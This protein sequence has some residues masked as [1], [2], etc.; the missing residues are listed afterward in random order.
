MVDEETSEIKTFP[1][2]NEREIL[3]EERYLWMARAFVVMMVLA[4]ICDVIL[5]I[6]LANVT[7]VVRVQP[8]YLEIQDKNQQIVSVERPSVETL[9][10]D[11]LKESLVRQYVLARYGIGSDLSELKERW[12]T[13]GPVYWMSESPIYD[14]FVQKESIPGQELARKDNFVRNVRILS[15]NKTRAGSVDG[16]DEW[17]VELEF[18][19]IDRAASKPVIS[20]FRADLATA[21]HP[22]KEGLVWAD[23][24]KNPLGF[25]VSDF[26][27]RPSQQKSKK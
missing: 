10:S 12:G 26:G 19:D 2:R 15:V 9:N 4:V 21:F 17:Q 13:N 1:A 22:T 5:L 23:R 6:A 14:E 11:V 18:Q 8:F 3:Q 24:L 27:I 20:Y 7:P 16:S 25:V